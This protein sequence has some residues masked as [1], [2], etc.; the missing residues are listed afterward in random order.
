V[1]QNGRRGSAA[2]L[3]GLVT[4]LLAMVLVPASPALGH[5]A[6]V[7][8]QPGAGY[9][10]TS[11]PSEVVLQFSE[12]VSLAD[13]ALTLTGPAGEPVPLR[14]TLDETGTAV[15]GVPDTE[16]GTGAYQVG[17]RVVA[18]DGDLITGTYPFGISTP[19]AA[20]VSGTADGGADR[21]GV[22]LSSALGRA[23]LFLGLS[24]ALGGAYLSWR[25]DDATGGLPGPRPLVR[26]G[27][28]VATAGT[29]ALLLTLAPLNRWATALTSPGAGRLVAAQGLLLILAALLAHRAPLLGAFPAL[30][31]IVILEGVRAHAGEA[32]GV[33]GMA[34]TALHLL[35][36]AL[37]LGGLVHA[38]RL[39]AA[40]RTKSLAV[41]TA[42][43]AY[44]R[45]ALILFV[46]V[47]LTGTL[48][49]LL[50]LPAAE[51]WTGTTY[52]RVLLVKLAL[53]AAV[54]LAAVA[55]RRRL[56]LSRPRRADADRSGPSVGHSARVEAGLLAGLVVVT[57]ALTSATPAR[58]VPASA[59]L[60]APIGPVLRTAER[61]A[62][63]SVSIV[64]SKGRIEIRADVPDDGDPPRVD[65]MAEV[66]AP[67]GDTQSLDLTTCG[68]SCWT[69][70]VEW[71]DGVN[72]V[73]VDVDAD[74]W[75]AGTARLSVPWPLTPA[76]TLLARVQ[77]AMG[78]RSAIDTVE[79]VT[80]GFGA[81]PA[82][83]SRRTGQ[84]YLDTQPWS[85]AGATD[86]VVVGEGDLRTLMFA[87]P[88][89][90]YH[91]AMRLDEQ[92]RV[93]AERI[94]TPNH[95]ITRRYSFP[96]RS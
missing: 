48:S 86:L 4:L 45:S 58:L 37:W 32:A 13:D 54:L 63:V 40:W 43:T 55:A 93:V 8:S 87:L 21:D 59:V 27:A 71:H 14:V 35:A 95:L 29:T 65:L 88:A 36:G 89:L 82:T 94:V 76:P 79:T 78:T 17:Y 75:Q 1:T 34:L 15:R 3:V 56:V 23:L 61:V 19:V 53:F 39:A 20:G 84:E 18:R 69:G 31:A 28:L 6:L 68:L 66:T 24:L 60:A 50:L 42:V 52:G 77:E 16:L 62:Q 22:R 33:A 72:T 83:S 26:T 9:A 49:A 12:G 25:V 96:E 67:S 10:L 57:A 81:L 90:G 73:D 92:D 7:S 51:D 44:A 30:L 74:R 2:H 47:A 64:A 85:E 80:S 38:L 11:A 70:P 46:L 91:F 41:H 5:A